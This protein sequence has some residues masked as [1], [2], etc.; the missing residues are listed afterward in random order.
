MDINKDFHML[1]NR[2]VHLSSTFANQDSFTFRIENDIQILSTP[3]ITNAPD[4]D[5]LSVS[6][7]PEARHLVRREIRSLCNFEAPS[8]PTPFQNWLV[9]VP[10][11][12]HSYFGKTGQ[13]HQKCFL[14]HTQSLSQRVFPSHIPWYLFPDHWGSPSKP[15]AGR[16]S[17]ALLQAIW[18]PDL[19][20]SSFCGL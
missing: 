18:P 9:G 19:S 17:P 13:T 15:V 16:K 1:I 7:S 12:N 8:H 4:G 5:L 2:E 6:S 11:H 3:P 14:L 10:E 20:L